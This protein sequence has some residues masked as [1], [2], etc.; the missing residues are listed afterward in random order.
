MIMRGAVTAISIRTCLNA[1][2]IIKPETEIRWQ[3]ALIVLGAPG[4]RR[5][6]NRHFV[7][8]LVAVVAPFPKSGD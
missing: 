2:E 6:I 3:V 5:A 8:P 4:N 1:L 7:A